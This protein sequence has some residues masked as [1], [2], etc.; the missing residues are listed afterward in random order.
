MAS[1]AFRMSTVIVLGAFAAWPV[2]TQGQFE[3]RTTG[4]I[5]GQV[6][7][8]QG[9]QPAFNV[10][11]S[12]D[13][14]SGGLIAQENTDRNGKFQFRNIKL[15]QYVITVRL[16]GYIEE[17]ETVELQQTPDQY[18]QIR[19]RPEGSPKRAAPTSKV[20]DANVPQEARKEFERGE[21]ALASV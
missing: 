11:V 17:R 1:L 10:L 13:V 3:G 8:A 16:P 15:D 12:C 2:S 14:F 18:L 21:E 7:Y 5:T 19:L 6:R 9:G 20:I 4:N